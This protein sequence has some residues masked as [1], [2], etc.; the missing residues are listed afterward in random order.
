MGLSVIV[1]SLMGLSTS[2]GPTF[3][4]LLAAHVAAGSVALAAADARFYRAAR[5]DGR[6]IARHLTHMLAGTIATRERCLAGD[7]E[8]C[9]GSPR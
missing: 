1:P 6:R 4:A 8:R 2:A 9:M 7:K 3:S 5:S